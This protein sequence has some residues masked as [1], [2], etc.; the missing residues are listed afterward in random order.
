MKLPALWIVA[1]FAAGAAVSNRWPEPLHLWLA[2]ALGAIVLSGILLW[3]ARCHCGDIR[4]A[5]MD[6]ARRIGG[7]R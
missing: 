2:A 6:R 4:S 7:W 3:R 1:A 5:R